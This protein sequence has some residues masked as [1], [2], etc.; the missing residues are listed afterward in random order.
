MIPPKETIVALMIGITYIGIIIYTLY[1]SWKQSKVKETTEK[2]VS[3][4][5]EANYQLLTI[6]QELVKIRKKLEE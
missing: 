1:L 2:L 4:S 5:S 6:S 3:Q